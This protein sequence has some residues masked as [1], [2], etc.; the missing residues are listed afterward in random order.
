[1][2]FSTLQAGLCSVSACGNLREVSSR[3]VLI[4]EEDNPHK[5]TLVVEPEAAAFYCQNMSQYTYAQYCK[6]TEQYKSDTYLVVDIGGGT[7]DIVA[8]RIVDKHSEPHMEIIHEPTGG[9]WGGSGVNA[10]F[11]KFIESLTQDVCFS[12]Y[13]QTSSQET[14]SKQQI[15]LDKIV[16]ESFECQKILFGDKTLNEDEKVSI[17]LHSSFIKCYGPQIEDE[18]AKIFKTEKKPQTRFSSDDNEL[19]IGYNKLK[20]FVEPI[21]KGI[22]QCVAKVLNNVPC[23]QTIYLIGGFGGCEY[24]RSELQSHFKSHYKFITPREKE[25]AV[26]KGAAMMR[27]NPELILARRVDATYGIRVRIPFIHQLH[28]EQYRCKAPGRVDM[29][30]NIFATFVEKGDVVSPD[31]VYMKT[32]NPERKEQTFMQVQIYSSAEKDIWYTTGKPPLQA[33]ST[34]QWVHVQKIGELKVPFRKNRVE[35][36]DTADRAI[37]VMFDFNTAEVI[38]TGRYRDSSTTFRLVLD[39]LDA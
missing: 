13:I 35:N 4:P 22:I 14:N 12:R 24:I 26:V 18:V 16:H 10:E 6:P 15:Y 32:F 38:V 34:R 25:H 31:Y 29:C 8:Y 27:K 20:L 5:I 30:S 39:F 28:D 17:N 1:M 19:R 37:D 3:N 33:M 7:V 9:S 11:K 21:V 2:E 23:V 36:D